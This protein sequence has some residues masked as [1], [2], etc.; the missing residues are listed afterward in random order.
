MKV[1]R[2]SAPCSDHLYPQEIF[3]VLIS[4]RGWVNPR[5]TVRPEGLYQ[6]KMPMTPSEIEPATLRLVAH[7]FNQMRYRVPSTS[8][9]LGPNILLNRLLSV[10]LSLCSSLN[11]SDQQ[12]HTKGKPASIVNQVNTIKIQFQLRTKYR[13]RNLPIFNLFE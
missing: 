8:S 4:V 2:L 9:P 13:D 10:T 12:Q 11:V 7:C 5:A 1:I 6:W 3:L